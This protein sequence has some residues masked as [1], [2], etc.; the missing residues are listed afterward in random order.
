MEGLNRVVR[1]TKHRKE[2]VAGDLDKYLTEGVQGA[3]RWRGIADVSAEYCTL[4]DRLGSRA[5]DFWASYM[6]YRRYPIFDPIRLLRIPLK[7]L[8]LVRP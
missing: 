7:E 8:P 3:F 1:D 4:A 5:E 2:I 6:T